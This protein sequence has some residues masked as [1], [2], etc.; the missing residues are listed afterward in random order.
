MSFQQIDGKWFR[1]IPVDPSTKLSEEVDG[2]TVP[3]DD[4]A[5]ESVVKVDASTKVAKELV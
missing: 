1:L 4:R 3:K 5:P 2:R